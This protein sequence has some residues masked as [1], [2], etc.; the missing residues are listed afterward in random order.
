M[1]SPNTYDIVEVA[2]K[3]NVHHV[4]HHV[5]EFLVAA[6]RYVTY[7]SRPFGHAS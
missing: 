4:G 2:R 3:D 5:D 7:L 1:K 6:L